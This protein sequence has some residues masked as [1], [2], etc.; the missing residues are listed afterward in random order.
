MTY[1]CLAS[2]ALLA[3]AASAC[4]IT[5]GGSAGSAG[6]VSRDLWPDVMSLCAE[7]QK[8]VCSVWEAMVVDVDTST[9]CRGMRVEYGQGKARKED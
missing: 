3:A 5:L 4:A 9:S 2:S 8:G 1:P 7:L 6:A